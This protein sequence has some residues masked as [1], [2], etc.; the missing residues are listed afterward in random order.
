MS[1]PTM[2]F[3]FDLWP[4]NSKAFILIQKCTNAKSLWWK[5]GKNMWNTFQDTVNNFEDARTHGRM[6]K[7]LENTM[8]A[9]T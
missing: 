8:L 7:Q 6:H 9:E 4:Q 3:N 2:T 5:F 1:D